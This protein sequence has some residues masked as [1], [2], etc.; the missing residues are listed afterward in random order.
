MA[1]QKWMGDH[2]ETASWSQDLVVYSEYGQ[3]QLADRDSPAIFDWDAA[4]SERHL[5]IGQDVLSVATT[6][7]F[8]EVVV[9]VE[10]W[11]N[12]PPIDP[13]ASD[14]IVEASIELSTGRASITSLSSDIALDH[15]LQPGWFRVRAEG[16]NLAEGDFGNPDRKGHD[17]YLLRLWPEAAA[18]PV[19]LKAWHAWSDSQANP[20]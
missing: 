10:A 9:R 2:D 7:M 12:Q 18:P 14:H 13:G 19:V 17:T 15:A 4:A 5:A 11:G 3:F 8:G 20:G 6:T 1:G 16:R